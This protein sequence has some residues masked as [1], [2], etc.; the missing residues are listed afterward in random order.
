LCAS[1]MPVVTVAHWVGR[2]FPTPDEGWFCQPGDGD[3]GEEYPAHGI[4]H[5]VEGYLEPLLRDDSVEEEECLGV[6]F[7]AELIQGVNSLW[8]VGV[9]DFGQPGVMDAGAPGP[10]DGEDG[11]GKTAPADAHERGQSGARGNAAVSHMGTKKGQ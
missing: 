7:R 11:G 1:Q 4:E 8:I 9:D 6:V 10:H 3:Q 2:L 5:L